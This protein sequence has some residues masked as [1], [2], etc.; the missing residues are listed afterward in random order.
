M[1]S[2][3]V[4]V[5]SPDP[6]QVLCVLEQA[7]D[8]ACRLFALSVHDDPVESVG[9]SPLNNEVGD[10]VAAVLER[11]LPAQYTRL[12][13]DLADLNATFTNAGGV[14]KNRYF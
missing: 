8:V 1:D 12:L 13:C 11:R 6:E 2:G 14:W 5:Y 7:R 10:L 9:V 4:F 3:S